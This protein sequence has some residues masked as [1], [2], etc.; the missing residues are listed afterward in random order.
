MNVNGQ[1]QIQHFVNREEPWQALN[2]RAVGLQSQS[3]LLD[4]RRDSFHTTGN[5]ASIEVTVPKA[6]VVFYLL[7]LS[8]ILIM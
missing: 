6:C 2:W 3:A 8:V 4:K 1:P 5:P 7:L